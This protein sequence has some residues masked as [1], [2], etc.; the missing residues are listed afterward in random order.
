MSAKMRTMDGL[1]ET[2]VSAGR[3]RDGDTRTHTVLLDHSMMLVLI[4]L[5]SLKLR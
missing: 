3:E 4:G 1:G 2:H 5:A